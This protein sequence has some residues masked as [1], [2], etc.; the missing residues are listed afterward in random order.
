MQYQEITGFVESSHVS[1]DLSLSLASSEN[2]SNERNRKGR[3]KKSMKMENDEWKCSTSLV[4][5]ENPWKIRKVLTT[6]DTGGLSRLLLREYVGEN[7]M[8]PV[9][10]AHAHRKVISGTGSSVSV[11]DVDTMS[12]HNLILKRWPSLNSFVL[13]G[14]WNRDFVLRRALNTGDEI[15]L[16]WDSFKHCFLFSVLKRNH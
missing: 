2:K 4:L 16:L 11:W 12:M 10:D 1:T 8:L 15:G 3:K 6:S 5:C 7:F 9:L 13:V 14:K